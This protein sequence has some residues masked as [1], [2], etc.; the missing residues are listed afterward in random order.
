MA[1]NPEDVKIW[2]FGQ[3]ALGGVYL[4]KELWRIYRDQS[5]KN[6]DA[7]GVLRE[8]RAEDRQ[9]LDAAWDRIRMLEKHAEKCVGQHPDN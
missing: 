1:V 3:L 9:D 5:H 6:T 8:K 2:L 4:L 7:I